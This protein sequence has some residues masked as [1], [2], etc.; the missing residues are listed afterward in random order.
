MACLVVEGRSVAHLIDDFGISHPD[1]KIV[2]MPQIK[3]L[4]GRQEGLV[5]A[6]AH[7]V[8]RVVYASGS[9]MP[10]DVVAR[11]ADPRVIVGVDDSMAPWLVDPSCAPARGTLLRGAVPTR[12][13]QNTGN[14]AASAIQGWHLGSSA[15]NHADGDDGGDG[16]SA[17]K[18]WSCHGC[19]QPHPVDVANV[20]TGG[21]CGVL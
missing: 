4:L 11:A 16:D 5:H 12:G 8:G 20:M 3:R 9:R 1:P 14:S 17:L 13:N 7:S 18:G 19:V 21:A 15:W 2:G 10:S 6:A